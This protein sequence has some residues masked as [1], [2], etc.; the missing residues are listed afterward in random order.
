LP[1]G[2]SPTSEARSANAGEEQKTGAGSEGARTVGGLGGSAPQ[3]NARRPSE[4]QSTEQGRPAS[5]APEGIRTPNLLFG[6][7]HTG[8]FSTLLNPLSR[9]ENPFRCRPSVP[10][11]SQR[12]VW[13]RCGFDHPI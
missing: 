8:H 6:A 1:F 12:S 2:A 13:V 5:S 11:S 4:V 3:D 9:N 7:L 10:T